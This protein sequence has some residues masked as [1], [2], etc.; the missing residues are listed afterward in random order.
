M[1]TLRWP[2][3]RA[4]M[5]AVAATAAL[6]GAVQLAP[7][8]A[9]L[10]VAAWLLL[11]GALVAQVA[12]G[13]VQLAYPPPPP[14]GFDLALAARQAP[15]PP[16]APLQALGRLLTLASASGLHAHTRL[17][18][19]LR[20]VA[21]DRL[22]WYHGIDLDRQPG[23]ARAVLG[24]TLW[25][26]VRPDPGPAPDRDAAGPTPAALAAVVDALEGLAR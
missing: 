22:A 13:W 6:A 20:P 10:A 18:A 2:L 3:L 19:R 9:P 17:R 1:R 24:E 21:A 11:L 4:G 26:L 8:H 14:S 16:P 15:P 25:A 23:P 7:E 5:L 12:V